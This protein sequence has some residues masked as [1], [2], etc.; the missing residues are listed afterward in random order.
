MCCALTWLC[1]CVHAECIIPC[2]K[3]FLL[4]LYEGR[5]GVYAVYIVI[6]PETVNQP[7]SHSLQL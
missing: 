4:L 2:T 5:G 3:A 7:Q 6:A 1:G